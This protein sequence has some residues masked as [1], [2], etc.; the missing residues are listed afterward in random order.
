[1]TG[2]GIGVQIVFGAFFLALLTM[3]LARRID[4]RHALDGD[5]LPEAADP[6]DAHL[7]GL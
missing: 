5:A 7:P 3:P 2:F 1:V 6:S 4:L